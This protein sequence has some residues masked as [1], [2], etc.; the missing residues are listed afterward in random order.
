MA[1]NQ[2]QIVI[3]G[4]GYAGMMAALRLSGKTKKH[5][6]EITLVNATEHFVER[7]RLHEVATG[8]PPQKRPLVEML[9][10]T[11]IQFRQGF[12][13]GIDPEEQQVI[14]DAGQGQETIS[15]DYL[16]YALGS[17]TDR[18]SVSGVDQYAFTLDVSG[19]LSSEPLYDRLQNLAK[20]GGQVVIVGSGATGIEMAGEIADLYPNLEVKM[21]TQGDFG[22]FK[23]ERV[24]R[25]MRQAMARLK[26]ELIEQA[27]VMAIGEDELIID[28]RENIP[29]DVCL[30]AGGFVALPLAQ[31]TGLQ[32][33]GRGQILVDPGLRALSHPNIYAI[34]DT[35]QPI[36]QPGAPLRMSLFTALV[37]GAHAADN[38]SRRLKGKVEKPLGF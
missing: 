38:L 34:G 26:V 35:A 17:R 12:V 20:S 24:Q 27:S 32:V 15:Y 25:Y 37:T 5:D 8:N 3:L 10:G 36:R 6:L 16:I 1:E 18:E 21:V 11:G 9:A 33:N 19:P 22:A 30:W 7:P 23:N 13:T 31:E 2:R 4:A 14:L 29:F 28:G